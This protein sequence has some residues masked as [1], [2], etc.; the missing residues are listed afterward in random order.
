MI[1]A[2]KKAYDEILRRI[3]TLE[4]PPGTYI[5][6]NDIAEQLEISK[7]PIREALQLLEQDKLVKI[8]PQSKTLVSKINVDEIKKSNFLRV[9]IEAEVIKTMIEKYDRE[10]LK[11]LEA[12][13]KKQESVLEDYEKLFEFDELDKEFHSIMFES[14][15]Q[16]ELNDLLRSKMGHKKRANRLELPKNGKVKKLYEDHKSIYDAIKEKD[17][18]KADECIRTHLSRTISRIEEL[19]KEKPHF[20]D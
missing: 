19:K 20:F 5:S 14:V 10:A 16:E 1:N 7:T 8:F 13:L 12:N 9:A 6:R 3:L 11:R 18:K 4:L 15:G 17:K 2:T